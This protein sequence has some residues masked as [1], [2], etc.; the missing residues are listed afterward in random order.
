MSDNLKIKFIFA[1]TVAVL[2]SFQIFYKQTPPT[3]E[4]KASSRAHTIGKKLIDQKF[5][6]K[7]FSASSSVRGLASADESETMQLQ[8]V[9]E[10][11]IGRD[12]WGHPF[13]YKKGP[14]ELI[15]WSKGANQQMDSNP[16]QI[17]SKQAQSDD[18]IVAISI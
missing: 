10:G 4:E 1:A 6:R 14:R 13:S 8:T 12:P 9:E 3:L 15:I 17:E 7:I 2:V 16:S 11:E 18:I 5:Q